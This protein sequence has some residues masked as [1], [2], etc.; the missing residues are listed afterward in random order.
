MPFLMSEMVLV[1]NTI[2]L[3]Q[4]ASNLTCLQLLYDADLLCQGEYHN[5]S[6]S[7]LGVLKT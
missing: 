6:S 3:G 5:A 1:S 2:L 4:L 7:W